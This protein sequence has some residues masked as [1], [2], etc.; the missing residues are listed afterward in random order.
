MDW[1][2]RCLVYGQTLQ[3]RHTNFNS[4]S[5]LHL[6]QELANIQLLISLL[7]HVKTFCV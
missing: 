2:D 4:Y 5:R 1:P 6:P 7:L 3:Y